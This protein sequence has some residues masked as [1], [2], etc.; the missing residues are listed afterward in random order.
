MDIKKIYNALADDESKYIFGNRLLFSLTGDEGYIENVIKTTSE[1]VEFYRKLER[2]DTRKVIFGAGFWGKE[3]ARQYYKY[4]FDCFVDNKAVYPWEEKEG[5]PVISFDE[6][7]HEYGD[8][9][10]FLGSRLYYTLIR[11]TQIY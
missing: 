9:T 5:L 4:G 1:G 11:E 3:L 8:A 2:T 7:M 6:Y 10:V